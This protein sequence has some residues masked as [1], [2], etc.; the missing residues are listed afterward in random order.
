MA[1]FGA[2]GIGRESNHVNLTAEFGDNT[3]GVLYA[4]GGAGGGMALY[5]DK[6]ELVYEY[7]WMVEDF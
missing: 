2:P 7:A 4:L 5:M 6:G 1:E 3:S